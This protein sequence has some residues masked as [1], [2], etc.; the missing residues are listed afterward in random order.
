MDN[1]IAHDPHLEAVPDHAGPHYNVLH[2]TLTQNGMSVEE[3]VQALDTSWNLNHDANIQ[4]WDQQV[5]EDVA[6]LEAQRQLQQQ[7]EEAQA[8][9]WQPKQDAKRSEAEKKLRMKDFDNTTSVG[10]YIAP[11]AQ[12]TLRQIEE[13]EYIKL[14]YLTPEGCASG[15]MDFAHRSGVF[16]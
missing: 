12:Y 14:W 9:Q 15:K 11:R 4:A 7:E 1:K 8:V 6:T 16:T 13:F 3:A 5:A 2:N 10:N